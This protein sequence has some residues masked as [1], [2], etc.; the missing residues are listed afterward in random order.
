[1]LDQAYSAPS[2]DA[3]VDVEERL[4]RVM[5]RPQQDVRHISLRALKVIEV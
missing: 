5:S 3:V 1:M 4:R 2:Y